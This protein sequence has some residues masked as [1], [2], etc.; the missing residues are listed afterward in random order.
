MYL[1][2]ICSITFILSAC[3]LSAQDINNFVVYYSD[4]APVSD[5]N[6]YSLIVFDSDSH[7]PIGA[8]KEQGKIV[9]GYLS[10]GEIENS[11]WYFKRFK[12]EKLLF[13]ENSNWKGSFFID[14]RDKKWVSFVVEELV[15]RILQKKF[16]GIFIDT[17]DNARPQYLSIRTEDNEHIIQIETYKSI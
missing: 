15:P 6:K 5:F 8:L 13:K 14:V 12:D 16:S 4:K 7:P 2:I 9:L 10:L 11:R 3:F 1:K 17:L